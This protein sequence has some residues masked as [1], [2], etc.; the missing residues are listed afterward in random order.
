MDSIKLRPLGLDRNDGR[1]R[2]DK[3]QTPL[4]NRSHDP[5]HI[6]IARSWDS[7][8]NPP[9]ER[10]FPLSGRILIL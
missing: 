4:N 5:S 3:D 9:Q 8:R 6:D 7:C 2:S 1:Q 10:G